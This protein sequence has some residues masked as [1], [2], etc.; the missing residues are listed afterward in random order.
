LFF[1][2]E[3][4]KKHTAAFSVVCVLLTV[5]I[6]LGDPT[7]CILLVIPFFMLFSIVTR[8]WSFLTYA[9]IPLAYINFSA[10]TYSRLLVT[11]ASYAWRGLVD[12][13]ESILGFELPARIAPWGRS[14]L[15]ITQDV[16]MTSLTFVALIVFSCLLLGIFVYFS[17]TK[18]NIYRTPHLFSASL[19]LLFVLAISMGTYV[20]ASVMPE[21][22]FS[23]IRTIALITLPILCLSFF[24]SRDLLFE[25]AKH[26]TLL[27]ILVALLLLA[28][29][30]NISNVYPKSMFDPINAVEDI[31]VSPL[32][33]HYVDS[34]LGTHEN[35]TVL[36]FDYKTV[37]QIV[38]SES[39]VKSII[40]SAI[41][42]S[43]QVVFNLKGLEY[44]SLYTS[45]E[46][47][48][49]ALDLVNKRNVIYSSGDIVVVT[50]ETR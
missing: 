31:R 34:F 30:R 19:C 32:S 45:D 27:F 18:G 12:F 10:T 13:F 7:S 25:I 17:R 6:T 15:L 21:V 14:S 26:K 5:L 50:H 48:S 46:A 33:I 20:G 38:S 49:E 28:S 3:R 1:F 23:D 2:I 44:G 35:G 47:Y 40:Q 43:S 8:R 16:L 4:Y 11:Y 36:A 42:P 22:A 39:F 29:F 37:S 41:P 24:A 9:I